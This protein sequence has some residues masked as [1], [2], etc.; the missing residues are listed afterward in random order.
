[1]TIEDLE[2]EL[3]ETEAK[4]QRLRAQ[5]QNAVQHNGQ[6]SNEELIEIVKKGLAPGL[7]E[8]AG[9]SLVST[10]PTT[11]DAAKTL[12]KRGVTWV[13]IT[14]NIGCG[15]LDCYYQIANDILDTDDNSLTFVKKL[16][17]Y[18]DQHSWALALMCRGII[19]VDINSLQREIDILEIDLDQLRK[20]RK[21]NEKAKAFIAKF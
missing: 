21:G 17:K 19:D 5:I 15:T 18:I 9:C 10:D 20:E 1:M 13:N 6:Y 3:Y 7:V 11:K 14:P 12:N 4:A 2:K 16:F 8:S